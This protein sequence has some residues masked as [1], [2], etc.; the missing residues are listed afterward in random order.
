MCTCHAHNLLIHTRCVS[1]YAGVHTCMLCIHGFIHMG[2]RVWVYTAVCCVHG[3]LYRSLYVSVCVML[4]GVS[5]CVCSLFHPQTLP[6]ASHGEKDLESLHRSG[7]EYHLGGHRRACRSGSGGSQQVMPCL[8][9]AGLWVML[10]FQAFGDP[11]DPTS[12]T[13]GSSH[14]PGPWGLGWKHPVTC[15]GRSSS[16]G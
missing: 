1:F 16:P 11:A 15:W 13:S 6:E 12:T 3:C 14:S 5:E 10:Q 4:Y 2:H 9:L 7:A 8:L